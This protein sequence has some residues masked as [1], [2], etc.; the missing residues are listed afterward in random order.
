L[1]A[2]AVPRLEHVVVDAK[3][4]AV[5]PFLVEARFTSRLYADEYHQFHGLRRRGDKEMAQT[6]TMPS[7]EKGFLLAIEVLHFNDFDQSKKLFAHV[8]MRGDC[9]S[10]L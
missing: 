2:L 10:S 8:E 5:K 7:L 9:A 3:V 6:S 1:H 4:R